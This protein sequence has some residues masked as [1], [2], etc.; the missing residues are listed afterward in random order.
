MLQT[1]VARRYAKSLL[2]LAKERGE[3]ETVNNDMKL[4]AEVCS[5][6]HDLRVLLGSPIISG[7]KKLSILKRV[8]SGK[9]SALSM[10]F[11]DVV[12]RKGRES[13]LEAIAVEFTRA[14]KEHKGIQTAIVTSAIGLDDKLRASV[15]KMVKESLNSEVELIEKVD[16]DLIGGFVLRVGDKQY[17]ASIARDLRMMKQELIDQSYVKKN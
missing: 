3:L 12:T 15:Y 8:F 1:K 14:Y 17:D 6:S 7:D 10:S 9:I 11:F 13:Q 16:K 4:L 2:D 5:S